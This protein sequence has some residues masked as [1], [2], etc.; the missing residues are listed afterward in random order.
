M[1]VMRLIYLKGSSFVDLRIEFLVLTG[2]ALVLNSWA[3]LSYKKT[4]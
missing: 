2:F 1:Q 4:A 3:I